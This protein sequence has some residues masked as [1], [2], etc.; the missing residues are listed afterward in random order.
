MPPHARLFHIVL[1]I[2]NKRNDNADEE[3]NDDDGD[4]DA[5]DD[6]ADDDVGTI[7]SLRAP[8]GEWGVR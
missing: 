5:D 3:D 7:V 6:A 1:V 8:V 2:I 4:D